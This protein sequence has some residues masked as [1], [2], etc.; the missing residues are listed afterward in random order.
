MTEAAALSAVELE[1]IRERL[2]NGVYDK[3]SVATGFRLLATVEAGQ[4]AHADACARERALIG[5][6]DAAHSGRAEWFVKH[7][8]AQQAAAEARAA[9]V[10]MTAER[11]KLLSL[12]SQFCG[13]A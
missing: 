4:Q 8:V 11:D 5:E 2:T 1:L 9:L 3:L 6:R 7:N 13:D 12:A 10:T